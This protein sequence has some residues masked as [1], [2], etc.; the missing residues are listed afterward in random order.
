MAGLTQMAVHLEAG[1][2]IRRH[3]WMPRMHLVLNSFP[4]GA[5]TIYYQN[6]AN[7]RVFW[8]PKILDLV[9]V[10]WEVFEEDANTG[11]DTTGRTRS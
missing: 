5:S 8:K 3:A 6:T 9:A 2:P 11:T 7:W 4:S 10:D 1:R